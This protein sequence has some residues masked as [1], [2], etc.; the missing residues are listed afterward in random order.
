[1]KKCSGNLEGKFAH[2][3]TDWEDR[4]FIFFN[5]SV[6]ANSVLR[7]RCRKLNG[8]SPA[9]TSDCGDINESC[10]DVWRVTLVRRNGTASTLDSRWNITCRTGAALP[11]LTRFSLLLPLFGRPL[12]TP[13]IGPFKMDGRSPP[14]SGNNLPTG[15]LTLKLWIND[16]NWNSNNY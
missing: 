7:K 14:D 4:S 12:P 16:I 11:G 6:G 8:P 1:M 9:L 13:A 2:S 10:M 5:V 3:S 15:L